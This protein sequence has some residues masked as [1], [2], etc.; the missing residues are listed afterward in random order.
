MYTLRIKTEKA[1]RNIALG[2]SYSVSYPGSPIF[3]FEV[4]QMK[5]GSTSDI[6]CFLHSE[7][8]VCFIIAQTG[9]YY[10][11]TDSGKTFEKL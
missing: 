7:D 6:K 3:E 5:K 4:K 8:G 11:M 9:E 1:L 10:I 2:G